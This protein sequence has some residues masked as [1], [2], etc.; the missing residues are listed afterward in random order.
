MHKVSGLN[1]SIR[2]RL[3]APRDRTVVTK[4]S[5]SIFSIRP[6]VSV[7]RVVEKRLAI[8]DCMAL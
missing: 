4:S 5:S 2:G 6:G 8:F 3:F 7:G 1:C